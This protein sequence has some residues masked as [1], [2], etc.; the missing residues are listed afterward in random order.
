MAKKT[1]NEKLYDSKDMPKVIKVT[2][3]VTIDRFGG[4]KML[5]S[6]PLE[7]DEVMK[8]VPYGKVITSDI[9]RKYLAKRH[10]ADF[11]CHLT[12][13]IFINIV[14]K[15]SAERDS[16]KTPYWRTLKKNGELNEK[17]PD[18]IEGQKMCLETE[19]HR[20]SKKGKRFFVVGY[21][22]KMFDIEVIK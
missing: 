13:G 20:I 7:Y 11:T 18:G 17:Y 3:P 21:S 5:I 8:K 6:P 19:G 2:D 10:N 15:A 22:E 4:N 14:A 16:N 12:C 9:I 1:Y